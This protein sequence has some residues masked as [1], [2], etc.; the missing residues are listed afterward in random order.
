MQTYQPDVEVHRIEMINGSHEFCQEFFT[1]VR[2]PDRDRVGEVDQGWTV[3][4][5]WMFHEKDALGGASQ[6]VTGSIFA[7]GAAEPDAQLVDL[8]RATGRIDDPVRARPDRRRVLPR[9]GTP[10]A[11]TAPGR[12]RGT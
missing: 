10:G 11:R 6:Y 12:R 5:R 8:A 7:G 2:V 3:G 4:T 9:A 1:D